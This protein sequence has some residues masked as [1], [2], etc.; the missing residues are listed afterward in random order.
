MRKTLIMLVFGTLVSC[1]ALNTTAQ[2]GAKKDDSQTAE[3][4]QDDHQQLRVQIVFNEFEGEKKIKSLPY[5]LLVTAN[6]TMPSGKIRTGSRV[7]IY[8]SPSTITYLD[9][10]TNIDCRAEAVREGKYSLVFALERSWVDGS[11]SIPAEEKGR[12]GNSNSSAGALSQPIVRQFRSDVTAVLRDGQSLETDLAT[13]PVSG[14]TIRIQISLTV[15][16]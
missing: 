14:K 5:A 4:G 7:P 2:E 13:D 8:T 6:K 16:K 10:G 9:V 12:A 3:R 1:F 15:L 11:V